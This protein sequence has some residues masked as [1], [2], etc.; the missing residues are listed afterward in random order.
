[1]HFLR[2]GASGGFCGSFIFS[3]LRKRRAKITG[4]SY[5]NILRFIFDFIAL[6]FMDG[7]YLYFSMTLHELLLYRRRCERSLVAIAAC[8]HRR[9]RDHGDLHGGRIVAGGGDN[10]V[11]D[12]ATDRLIAWLT[13]FICSDLSSSVQ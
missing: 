2:I 4:T 5:C 1:M 3:C 10:D 9:R 6:V 7:H 11:L 13:N 12:S 8:D